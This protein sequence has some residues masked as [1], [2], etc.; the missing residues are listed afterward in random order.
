MGSADVGLYEAVKL[1][2]NVGFRAI[3]YLCRPI[4]T[5]L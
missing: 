1:M 3:S 5:P 4:S 2:K